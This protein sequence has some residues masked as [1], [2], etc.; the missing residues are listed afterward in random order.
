MIQPFQIP[1]VSHVTA[2]PC[3]LL[4]KQQQIP[5]TILTTD[6][7]TIYYVQSQLSQGCSHRTTFQFHSPA[8]TMNFRRCVYLCMHSLQSLCFCLWTS[9]YLS[10]C[11]IAPLWGWYLHATTQ[12]QSMHLPP[13]LWTLCFTVANNSLL[14]GGIPWQANTTTS[15]GDPSRNPQQTHRITKVGE[16]YQDHSV[17]LPT[18][19]HPAHWPTS[20]T[21]E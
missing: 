3:P 13:A 19:H 20:T 9:L 16:D 12:M 11:K 7:G 2:N 8:I 21:R 10:F 5:F 1:S 17:Q 18:H 6:T 15:Y 4:Q 14:K